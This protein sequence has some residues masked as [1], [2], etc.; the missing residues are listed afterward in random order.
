MHQFFPASKKPLIVLAVLTVLVVVSALIAFGIKNAP[1]KSETRTETFV[2]GQ[3][4]VIPTSVPANSPF[5]AS[6]T[7]AQKKT[8][9]LK[10]ASDAKTK[11][12]TSDQKAV[13]LY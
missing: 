1:S 7:L 9:L 12:L 6:M 11:P 3:K 8:L 2:P 13:I 5:V 10:L 4:V